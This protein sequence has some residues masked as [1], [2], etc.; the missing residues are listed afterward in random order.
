MPKKNKKVYD[1]TD[2]IKNFAN[3]V[4]NNLNLN[5][6]YMDFVSNSD[7]FINNKIQELH[8]KNNYYYFKVIIKY[9]DNIYYGLRIC[10]SI[11]ELLKTIKNITYIS[12]EIEANLINN[13]EIKK[14]NDFIC[15][16]KNNNIY[17]KTKGGFITITSEKLTSIVIGPG[18][19]CKYEI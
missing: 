17:Y 2:K 14:T 6:Y 10:N 12:N 1:I 18:F 8:L 4:E 9:K 11:Y 16:L 3:E 15:S 5:Y 19:I 13:I 7:G